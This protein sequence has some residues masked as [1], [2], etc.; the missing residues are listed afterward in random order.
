MNISTNFWARNTSFLFLSCAI[1]ANGLSA[2]EVANEPVKNNWLTD[3]IYPTSHHNP[4]QT[5][6]TRIAGPVASQ[7]LS[8]DDVK[9]VGVTFVSNPT[10][11]HI[12]NDRIIFVSSVNGIAKVLATGDAFE[13]VSFLPYPGFEQIAD[14][15][16]TAALTALLDKLDT[17][18][19]AHDDGAILALSA[20][21]DDMG[22]SFKTV[23]NGVYNMIDKDHNHYAVY[24]GV[25]VLK[26][27]DDGLVN[28][29]LR[30]VKTTKIT[31]SLPAELARSVTRVLGVGMTYDGNI[32]IAAPGMIA[33]LDRD[34]NMMG[35]VT[36][37]GEMVDNGIA[38]D[39]SG[40]YVVSSANMYKVVWTGKKLSFD[41]ADGGWASPYDTMDGDKAVALGALSR[42]SGTTPTLMGFGDDEDKLVLIADAD[43]TG[44]KLVAF[45]R[46]EIPAG[47]TRKPG[48]KSPRIADQIRIDISYLTIEP[49]AVVKGYGTVLLN[50]TFPEPSPTAGDIFGNAMTS[51]ITRIAPRGIQKFVWNP[52]SNAF[53]KSWTNMTVDNTDVMVP[54]VSSKSNVL[55]AANKVGLRYEYVGLDWDT[56]ELKGRWTFPTDSALYNTWGGI[57]YFLE[58]GDLITGGFFGAK[59]VNFEQ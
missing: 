5:D 58:D 1:G 50:A 13:Q 14:K 15:A 19:Q 24:G 40:I 18:R 33:L 29:P 41:E 44:T 39:E 47:F 22:F 56:G 8:I 11:K 31:D 16:S 25:N 53:E 37:P 48:T 57:G 45:W 2:G 36:F 32:A 51:G 27:T 35:Y 49:S 7:N 55:Y 12:G 26:S 30:V 38:I 54:H 43:E 46:D 10:M 20:E 28:A 3:S 23:P 21:M 34:L 42:G 9:T 4:A 59:R 17:A 6:T 52:T